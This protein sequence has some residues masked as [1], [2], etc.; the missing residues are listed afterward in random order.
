[1]AIYRKRRRIRK[2]EVKRL[3][4]EMEGYA[5]SSPF[6]AGDDVDLAEMGDI[7]LIFA[8]GKVLGLIIEGRAFPSIRGI[9]ESEPSKKYVTVDSG[10]VRFLYN[11]ADVMA[12]GIVDADPGISS[13]DVVWVREEKHGKP[14][15]IGMA[16][17]S[18]TEMVEKSSGKAV[19]TVHSIGDKIWELDEQ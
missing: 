8:H 10:A 18:G 4:A 3:E 7:T 19:K 13:G 5:G 6:S 14:L 15:V 16:L 2:K 17:M 12:P 11:G 1:M 9:L